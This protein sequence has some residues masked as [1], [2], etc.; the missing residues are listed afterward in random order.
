M[1]RVPPGQVRKRASQFLTGFGLRIWRR[2]RRRG[3]ADRGGLLGED[4][5]ATVAVVWL[6]DEPDPQAALDRNARL[7]AA[8]DRVVVVTSDWS[9]GCGPGAEGRIYEVVPDRETRQRFCPEADWPVW[10]ER[11]MRS[12]RY[13]WAPDFE[14]DLSGNNVPT[15]SRQAG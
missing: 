7:L 15:L 10:L 5:Q 4:R 6:I 11:R 9:L 12:L 1:R 13:A 14:I 8:F 2:L 3:D